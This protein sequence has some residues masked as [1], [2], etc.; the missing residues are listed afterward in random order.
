[1]ICFPESES[2]SV[3]IPARGGSRRIPRKNLKNFCGKPLV[4]WTIEAAQ[5]SKLVNKVIVSTDDPE[6]AGLCQ[7]YGI[8]SPKLRA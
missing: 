3:V 5:G 4:A 1:M 7:S 2:V 6:I 8:S